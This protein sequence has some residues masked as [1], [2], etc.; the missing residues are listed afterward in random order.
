MADL[1]VQNALLLVAYSLLGYS[2]LNNGMQYDV[3]TFDCKLQPQHLKSSILAEALIRVEA[4][5]HTHVYRCLNLHVSVLG[6][7]YQD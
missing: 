6:L 2:L 3:K 5:P 1:R 7:N 4:S